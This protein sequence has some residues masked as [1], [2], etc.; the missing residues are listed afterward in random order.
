MLTQLVKIH[1]DIAF[2]NKISFSDINFWAFEKVYKIA[3][4]AKR[5]RNLCGLRSYEYEISNSSDL[6]YNFLRI[7]GFFGRFFIIK[8]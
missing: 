2:A 4:Y 5:G 8:S 1:A 3:L 6:Y 7:I